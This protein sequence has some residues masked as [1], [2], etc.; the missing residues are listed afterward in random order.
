MLSAAVADAGI[1]LAVVGIDRAVRA[2][3]AAKAA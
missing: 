3:E 2:L 1:L